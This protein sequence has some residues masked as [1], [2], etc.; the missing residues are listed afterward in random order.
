MGFIVVTSQLPASVYVHFYV[1]TV[2]ICFFTLSL[3]CCQESKLLMC[4]LYTCVSLYYTRKAPLK[5]N[6]SQRQTYSVLSISVIPLRYNIIGY[7][8]TH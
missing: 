6:L 3:C 1:C 4:F 5:E 2:R 8:Y 7:N